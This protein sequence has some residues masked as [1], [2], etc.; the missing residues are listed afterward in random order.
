MNKVPR[1]MLLSQFNNLNNTISQKEKE[2]QEKTN[3]T[4]FVLNKET[5]TIIEEL[6]ILNNQRAELKKMLEV[7]E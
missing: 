4:T 6:K 5:S 3:P 7:E 2:L 1:E